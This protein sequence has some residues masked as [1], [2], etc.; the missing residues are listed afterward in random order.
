MKK[1]Y[2]LAL[3]VIGFSANSF[4]QASATAT[5]TIISPISISKTNDLNFGLVASST[6][7]GTVVL[8]PA[9]ARTPTGVTLSSG[10]TT[11]AASFGVSGQGAYTYAI[12][13]PSSITLTDGTNFMTVNTFTST[14]SGTGALSGG[15]QTVNVGAT[16]NV[17]ANQVAGVYTTGTP[18]V[19]TVAY[20]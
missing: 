18:F 14:P 6:S 4:A 5:A 13:L 10:G 7:A 15:T 1:I 17:L 12:T 2:L 19:V 9:G 8:T 11:T 16:L 20:N 3:A